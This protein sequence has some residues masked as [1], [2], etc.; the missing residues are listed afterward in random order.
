MIWR[1]TVEEGKGEDNN[2]AEYIGASRYLV[3][4]FS[5]HFRSCVFNLTSNEEIVS[6]RITPHFSI[7]FL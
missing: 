5:N 7:R 1:R 6:S 3:R 2:F 4:V